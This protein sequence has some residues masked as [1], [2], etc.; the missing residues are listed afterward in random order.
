LVLS[1]AESHV[2]SY[3]ALLPALL[4]VAMQFSRFLLETSVLTTFPSGA[5]SL[6]AV[7]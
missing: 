2:I 4:R 7:F 3:V 6:L 1:A 5:E